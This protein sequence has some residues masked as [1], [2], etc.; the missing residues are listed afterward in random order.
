MP[1]LCPGVWDMRPFVKVG[2]RGRSMPGLSKTVDKGQGAMMSKACATV[3]LC[4]W[5][6]GGKALLGFH[7]G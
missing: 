4:F 2:Y 3:L 7:V 6:E 5:W 1:K